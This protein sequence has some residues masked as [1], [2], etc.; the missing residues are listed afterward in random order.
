MK[1]KGKPWNCLYA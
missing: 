1:A